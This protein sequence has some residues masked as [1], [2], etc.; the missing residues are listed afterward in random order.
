MNRTQIFSL[1]VGVIIFAF[2]GFW[3]EA[4]RCD[5]IS[6]KWPVLG[7]VIVILLLIAVIAAGVTVLAKE[8]TS[9]REAS[10]I[11]SF[12]AVGL[13]I[14]G[15]A[16][17]ALSK[18]APE[19]TAEVAIEVLP[20]GQTDP[21]S[22][23]P[24]HLDKDLYNQFRKTKA[25]FIK[26]Q[27]TLESLLRRDKIRETDWF[28]QFKNDIP[29]AVEELEDKLRVEVPRNSQWI[30]LS[31]TCRDKRESAL[32][33]NEML[34]L[35]LKEQQDIAT[36]DVRMKLRKVTDQQRRFR[37]ELQQAEDTLQTIRAKTE[38]SNLDGAG[39]P[40]HIS[41]KTTNL[42]IGCSN[43]ENE[44]SIVESHIVTLTAQTQSEKKEIASEQIIHDSA[45]SILA[46]RLTLLELELAEQNMTSGEAESE[47]GQIQKMINVINRKMEDRSA[48]IAQD[49]HKSNLLAAEAE[50][51]ALT[52]QHASM[53]KQLTEAKR[54]AKEFDNLRSTYQQYITIRDEKQTLLEEVSAH[55]EKL[56]AVLESPDI[57]RVKN[58]G[59]ASEALKISSPRLRPYLV[60][61][62]LLGLITSLGFVLLG[63]SLKDAGGTD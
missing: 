50:R 22:F 14:G 32:I 33:V 9:L 35:F 49:I 63:P 18:V 37:A 38:Y 21:F 30:E 57:S 61:G 45:M 27:S 11:V 1:L 13:I 53:Q 12:T 58:I 55:I 36:R 19:Y 10:V 43:L 51:T 4:Q 41:Q 47:D 39:L 46:E 62:I 15:A 23:G 42:E 34:G 8:L 5:I 26:Q 3:L 20:P 59:L 29:E 2:V 40:D 7:D 24:G 54:E 60:S 56:Y 31:M 44:L 17:L 16:W 48:K 25:K 52:E 6:N 28:E